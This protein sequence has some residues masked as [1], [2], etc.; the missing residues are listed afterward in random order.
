[1]GTAADSEGAVV[2]RST[3]GEV[4]PAT[5]KERM[6]W[7]TYDWANS[8]IASAVLVFALPILLDDLAFGAGSSYP[9]TAF[10]PDA[11]ASA[12]PDFSK[13]A[14]ENP[15]WYQ[16]GSCIAG[17][18]SLSTSDRDYFARC[19]VPWAGGYIR[20]T[21]FT[22]NVI[23]VSVGVQAFTFISVSAL[24]DHGS[25]RK[26]F[27]FITAFIGSL[28]SILFV[29]PTPQTLWLAGLFAVLLNVSYGV[30]VVFYN[31][32]LPLLTNADPTMI[33]LRKSGNTDP[34]VLQEKA[35]AIS[36]LLSTHGFAAGY[37]SGVFGAAAAAAFYVIWKSPW[38]LK[39]GIAFSGV[40]WLLFS[41]PTFLFLKKRPGPPLPKHENVLI[42]SWKTVFK[43]FMAA[44]KIPRTFAFMFCYFLFADGYS[45]IASVAVLF[46]KN[47]LKVD[48]ITVG[49]LVVITPL[50]AF[51][52]NYFF[53]F[54][55]TRLKRS[56][57]TMLLTSLVLY[58]VVSIYGLLGL[59]SLPV[60]FKPYNVINGVPWELYL[61]ACVHGMLLGPTQSYSRVVFSELI[62]PGR[63]A[64]FFGLF[65]ISDKGSSWMGP[66]VVASLNNS[67]GTLRLSFIFFLA[68][69]ALPIPIIAM[70]NV[71]KGKEDAREISQKELAMEK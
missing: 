4:E 57:K 8:V 34:V 35:E 20:H 69:F 6:G 2:E 58:C 64:E 29:I 11:P 24:A 61:F 52:G 3:A 46:A 55:Q 53:Y 19:V 70:I 68:V 18:E 42:Y 50:A 43:T 16:P 56:A 51:A 59:T 22:L 60:G 40:W 44:P 7:I 45:T 62:P 31:A 41:I 48:Q 33:E 65:E 13:I 49:L 28:V 10:A 71:A 37:L 27:L 14:S 54:I 1:M 12:L 17:N 30:S 15:N 26:L 47:E 36:N 21:S 9:V 25:L 63:E 67:G 38:G 5:R 32:F 39:A 66:L 23:S